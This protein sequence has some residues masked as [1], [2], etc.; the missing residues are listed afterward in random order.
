MMFGVGGRWCDQKLLLG[1]GSDLGLLG[2]PDLLHP[3]LLFLLLLSRLLGLLLDHVLSGQPVLGL[4]L[5]GKVHGVVDERE[6]G[7]LA[8][9]EVGLEAVGED[10]IWGALVHLGDL[11]ADLSLGDRRPESRRLKIH[12][13][14]CSFSNRSGHGAVGESCDGGILDAK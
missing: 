5:L 7:R 3:V 10:A 11:F 6:T 9:A 13:L 2:A 12:D 14:F 8:T 1:G 4:K